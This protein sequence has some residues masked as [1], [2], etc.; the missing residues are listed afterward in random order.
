MVAKKYIE[1]LRKVT[2]GDVLTDQPMSKYTSIKVGGSAD[3]VVFPEDSKDL[4]HIIRYLKS[5]SLSFFVLGNGT[6]LLV[7]DGGVEDVV[8]SLSHGFTRMELLSQ[9]RFEAVFVEAGVSLVRLIR[10]VTD[11]NLSGLEFAAGI[12]GTVGGGLFMNAG[13]SFGEMKD[14]THSVTL[15]NSGGEIVTKKREDLEFSYRKLQLTAGSIILNAILMLKV[16]EKLHIKERVQDILSERKK[17]Q[18]LDFPNAGS[19]FKNPEGIPA[20]RLIDQTGLKGFQIGDAI[21]SELHANFI[22]NLGNATGRDVENLIKE[23]Q[24][25][26]YKRTGLMLEPEIT[27]IG[28]N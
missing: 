18:P 24:E 1:G 25:R 28:R 17:K 12:P 13:G 26:V 14:V 16:N 11:C 6:N 10:F 2:R 8:I 3:V 22:I 15:M 19:I 21:V 9:E 5:E 20:G 4:I 27:I 7:R 23:V